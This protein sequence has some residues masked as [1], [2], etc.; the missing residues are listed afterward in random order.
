MTKQDSETRKNYTN[1][2]P[3]KSI[4]GDSI[5]VADASK[6]H[7]KTYMKKLMKKVR[8]IYNM[9][10]DTGTFVIQDVTG[11]DGIPTQKITKKSED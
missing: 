5:K 6:I 8:K 2:H 7:D 3:S 9:K 11:K 1:M 10:P 4:D